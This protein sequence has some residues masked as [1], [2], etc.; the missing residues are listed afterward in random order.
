MDSLELDRHHDPTRQVTREQVLAVLDGH[1]VA[2]P[3]CVAR[4]PYDVAAK[5]VGYTGPRHLVLAD[6]ERNLQALVDDGLAI[7]VELAGITHYRRRGS[8]AGVR[9]E[10]ERGGKIQAIDVFRPSSVRSPSP[11]GFGLGLFGKAEAEHWAWLMIFA[12]ARTGD[13][14]RPISTKEVADVARAEVQ[15]N[16]RLRDALRNPFF[17]PNARELIDRG[18]AEERDGKIA[19][20]MGALVRL[21]AME[22]VR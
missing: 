6:V 8:I 9:V 4:M 2:G 12:L 11:I 5:L 7:T 10:F 14:W 15:S 22:C 18:W 13:R 17:R 1:G 16:G 19:F 3:G 21:A 20:T